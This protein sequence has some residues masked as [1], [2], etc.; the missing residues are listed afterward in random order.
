M[1]DLKQFSQKS[2]DAD[3]IICTYVRDEDTKTSSWP[4]PGLTPK[5]ADTIA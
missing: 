5:P 2:R 4:P 1:H 3:L